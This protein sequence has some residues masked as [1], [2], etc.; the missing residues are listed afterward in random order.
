MKLFINDILIDIQRQ[1][2]QVPSGSYDNRV[3][4][5]SQITPDVMRGHVLILHAEPS[6]LAAVLRL[7]EQR[8]LGKLTRITMVPKDY[9][10]IKDWVKA[11]YKVVKAGGGVV[12]KRDKVLMIYRLGR[13]DLP[14]GKLERDETSMVGALREVTEECSVS[15]MADVK[16]CSTWHTYTDG[17]RKSIK[18][19]TWYLMHCQDDALMKPQLEEGIEDLRWMSETELDQAVKNSFAS[20]RY[21]VSLYKEHQNKK[22]VQPA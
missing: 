21:V 2:G 3:S 4:L 5:L 13:W 20:I 14:K 11:E 16:L 1:P 15:V 8:K 7:M 17:G 9:K 19:T 22:A 18:K 10:A 6:Y 12:M